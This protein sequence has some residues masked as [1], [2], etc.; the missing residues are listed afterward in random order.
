MNKI[1]WFEV[2]LVYEM[3]IVNEELSSNF[4]LQFNIKLFNSN[5]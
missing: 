3:K 5:Y 1:N 4:F 2:S